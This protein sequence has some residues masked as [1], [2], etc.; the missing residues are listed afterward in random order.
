MLRFESECKRTLGPTWLMTGNKQQPRRIIKGYITQGGDP[1]GTGEGGKIYGEPFKGDFRTRLR[2]CGRGSIA[3]ANAGKDDNGS[4]FFFTRIIKGFITEDGDLRGTGEGGKIYG[5]PFKDDFRTRLCSCERGS[6][7]GG[8]AGEDDNGFQFF[9][10]L[11]STLEL[12]NKHTIFCKGTGETIYNML[13][14]E[15]ALADENAS[16]LYP[17]RLVKTMILNNP[18]SDIIPRIIV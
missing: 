18:F 1:R 10:T 2:S 11:G 3:M 12:H 15:E 8:Y 14:F 4:Q 13:E 7:A 5:E 17:P 9:F 16:P 6:I